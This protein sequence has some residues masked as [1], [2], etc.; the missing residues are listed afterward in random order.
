MS[1]DRPASTPPEPAAGARGSAWRRWTARLA[2]EGLAGRFALL[3]VG[4]LLAANL[5]ALGV[6]TVERDR[7][8]RA[9]REEREVERI[10]SLVPAIEAAAPDARA[11]I[12]RQASTRFSRV[13]VDGRPVVETRPTGPRSRAL[14][15]ELA[16]DLP[17]RDARA[18]IMVR[19]GRGHD[20]DGWPEVE[21]IA[22][23]IRLQ[24]SARGADHGAQ[25]LNV[26][27][28]GAPARPGGFQEEILLVILALSLLS[29][30]AVGLAFV[31]RLTRPLSALAAA[32]RAAGRGDRTVRVDE[33]G[34][35]ELREAARAFNEMQS[36][37]AQFDGERM[38]TLAA[39]GHDLRTPITSL[40]IRAEMLEEETAAPMI[41]TLDEM[42]VMAEGLIAWARGAADAETPER[43]DLSA[44]L[45]RLCEERGAV[46]KPAAPVWISGRP[47]A[48]SRA[49]GNL[50]DNAVR[51]GGNA[52]VRLDR[53]DRMA[54]VRV[55]DDG[56]GIPPDRIG[57]VFE[58]FVR[59]E[60]SRSPDTGGAGLGLSI[61]RSIIA[62][63][64]GSLD[65]ENRAEGGLNVRVR[66]PL[67]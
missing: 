48:L 47:V 33:G 16:E 43:V 67:S 27:A 64:G 54:A 22:A 4:A 10:V 23:S 14:T 25:W 1:A 65:L 9:A 60:E 15:A 30:L 28:R 37:I 53:E 7:M 55:E 57:D 24:T 63:H 26:V 34:A 29:V 20:G 5:V 17:G 11:T 38:R 3:L 49:F 46:F 52:R 56:P 50:I 61:A 8:D 45:G 18:A 44:L 32:A 12:A 35:R 42:T 2:P 19:R 51:Y 40:R 31:R 58:P 66:L 36:R 6:L 62:M 13:S 39:V 21:T 41:R 59:V